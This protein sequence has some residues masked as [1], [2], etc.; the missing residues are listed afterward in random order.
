MKE[1]QNLGEY[2]DV[3]K[4]IPFLTPLIVPGVIGQPQ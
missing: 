2:F 3:E 1:M 4:T